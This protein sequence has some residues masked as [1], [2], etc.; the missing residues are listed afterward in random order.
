MKNIQVYVTTLCIK[1]PSLTINDGFF[2]RYYSIVIRDDNLLANL[3]Q[4][5]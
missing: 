2:V 4:P 1:K 3:L 5:T